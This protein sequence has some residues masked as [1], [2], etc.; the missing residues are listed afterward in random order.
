MKKISICIPDV[1]NQFRV[2]QK[3]LDNQEGNY[4]DVIWLG[5]FFDSF[6]DNV[7]I[8]K[9]TA[10]WLDGKMNLDNHVFLRSNHDT[11]YMYPSNK[12]LYCSGFDYVKSKAIL[13]VLDINKFRDKTKLFHRINNVFFS[14]AGISRK[15]LEYI[16]RKGEIEEVVYDPDV[17][18]LQLNSMMA[19]AHNYCDIGYAHPLY[20]A[21]SDRGG[22][23]EQGGLTWCD[24]HSFEPIPNVVNIFGHTPVFPNPFAV[25]L[26]KYNETIGWKRG[27]TY[28]PEKDTRGHEHLVVNGIGIGLDSHL[29][30]FAL[31]HEDEN[32]LEIFR[33]TYD[34]KLEGKYYYDRNILTVEKVWDKKL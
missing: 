23:A 12:N 25:R 29:H 32:R 4:T 31:Y 30:T 16:H 26:A 1:H 7:D 14:H 28:Y 8:V 2:A 10:V 17:I 11:A 3:I 33:I 24:M 5:D 6:T 20:D 34:Q 9:E 19:K 22:K 15:F 18:E 27:E 13:S 21:G